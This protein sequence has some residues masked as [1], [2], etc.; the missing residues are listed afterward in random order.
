MIKYICLFH[1][2][3]GKK[4]WKEKHHHQESALDKKL[5]EEASIEEKKDRQRERERE[6]GEQEIEGEKEG[7]KLNCE[8]GLI[9]LSF[10]KVVTSVTH[11]SIYSL[12]H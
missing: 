11:V 10:I 2:S 6:M 7:E 12:G 1:E 5:R 3:L 9:R 8:V 4:P